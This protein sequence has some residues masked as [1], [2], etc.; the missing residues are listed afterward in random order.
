MCAN[1][2]I[3]VQLVDSGDFTQNPSTK[4]VFCMSFKITFVG[5]EIIIGHQV[6]NIGVIGRSSYSRLISVEMFVVDKGNSIF[7]HKSSSFQIIM[8]L[9]F[10]SQ[11]NGLI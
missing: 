9:T 4:I 1:H 5:A 10:V 7:V 8:E 11:G 3:E 6:E 2:Q